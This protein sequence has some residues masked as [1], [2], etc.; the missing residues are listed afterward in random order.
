MLSGPDWRT[1]DRD[2]VP[3]TVGVINGFRDGGSE[4]L[5]YWKKTSI[6]SNHRWGYRFD[7]KIVGRADELHIGDVVERGE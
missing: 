5:V 4:V 6:Q 1:G 3:G 7:V 2:G